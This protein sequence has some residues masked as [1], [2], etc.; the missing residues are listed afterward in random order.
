[1]LD[2]SAVV[3]YNR[4]MDSIPFKRRHR[5]NLEISSS[6]GAH[7]CALCGGLTNSPW[8][9]E[10]VDGGASIAPAVSEGTTEEDGGLGLHPLGG[11]CLRAVPATHRTKQ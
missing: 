5:D 1:M 3:S 6:Q 11:C 2:A 7:E 9:I 4:G 8:V 10:L